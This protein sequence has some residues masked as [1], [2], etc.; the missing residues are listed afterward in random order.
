[1][2]GVP[3][4]DSIP[5]PRGD[6]LV[7]ASSTDITLV[8][9][10]EDFSWGEILRRSAASRWPGGRVRV[11]TARTRTD[12][13][14]RCR[15]LR[16]VMVVMDLWLQ[17]ED[18]FDV[19]EE[20][21]ALPTNPRVLAL[22]RRCDPVAMHR[23]TEGR[24][25]GFV[26][27]ISSAAEQL[28][29]ALAA[30][31]AGENYFPAEVRAAITGVRAAPDAYFKILSPTLQGLMPLLGRGYADQE[32]SRRLGREPCTIK[33][34][35]LEVQGKLGLRREELPLWAMIAGFVPPLLPSPPCAYCE[36]EAS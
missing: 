14:R 34:Q 27:K 23:A 13:L 17:A 19:L 33:H 2:H 4:H 12:G 15:E 29:M 24:L 25:A 6:G 16:P 10:D 5:L 36:R 31:E 26:W 20:L 8:H 1:M 32:V 30:L 3:S 9:L 18:G 7:S 22:T 35:R 21:A 11:V 28:G